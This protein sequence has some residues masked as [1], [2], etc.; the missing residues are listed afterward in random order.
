VAVPRAP[1]QVLLASLGGLWPRGSGSKQGSQDQLPARMK[2][3]GSGGSTG[4]LDTPRRTQHQQPQEAGGNAAQLRHQPSSSSSRAPA[5]AGPRVSATGSNSSVGLGSQALS[6]ELPR[7]SSN[8]SS[9]RSGGTTPRSA[10]NNS[11]S[12]GPPLAPPAESVREGSSSGVDGQQQQ[13]QQPQPQQ[14]QQQQ[15]PGSPPPVATGAATQGST[16][17]GGHH[18]SRSALPAGAAAVLDGLPAGSLSGWAGGD[19]SLQQRLAPPAAAH[20]G[21]RG[22]TLH[23]GDQQQQPVPAVAP[24][25]PPPSTLPA[26]SGSAS[27]AA[28]DWA[29]PSSSSADKSVRG[30]G[31]RTSLAQEQIEGLKRIWALKSRLHVPHGTQVPAGAAAAAAAAAVAG[32]PLPPPWAAA[33]DQQSVADASLAAAYDAALHI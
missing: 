22:D 20:G 30:N 17:G 3:L 9:A 15:A 11:S 13:P 2:S 1:R 4:S 25:A 12:L 26:V 32:A 18:H 28:G 10:A 23:P 8:M 31:A 5:A 24:A 14:Q 16:H 21:R 19:T 27:P 29:Y 33:R 7:Q 6:S